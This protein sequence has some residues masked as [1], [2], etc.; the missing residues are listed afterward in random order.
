MVACYQS[1]DFVE[2]L[3]SVRDSTDGGGERLHTTHLN[4][5]KFVGM[6]ALF[7]AWSFFFSQQPP[8]SSRTLIRGRN[9]SNILGLYHLLANRSSLLRKL[10]TS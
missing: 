8:A 9:G 10:Y 2:F 5:S 4:T 3:S 1:W 7:R 6:N